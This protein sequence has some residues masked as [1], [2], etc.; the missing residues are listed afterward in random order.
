[1]A[2]CRLTR[3][4]TNSATPPVLRPT[5]DQHDRLAGACL[6]DIEAKPG[7]EPGTC[8][9]ARAR[10]ARESRRPHSARRQPVETLVPA[11]ARRA[12]LG[13]SSP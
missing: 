11:S 6:G 5:R 10:H 3:H 9:H 7:V 4:T 2:S 13:H 8:E 12:S 1:M